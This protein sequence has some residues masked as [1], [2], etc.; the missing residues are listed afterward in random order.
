VRPFPAPATKSFRH[1]R[2][3]AADGGDLAPTSTRTS[4]CVR[5]C[6]HPIGAKFLHPLRLPPRGATHEKEHC[7]CCCASMQQCTIR[8]VHPVPAA[9]GT[10]LA[11]I[12]LS[13]A[14]AACLLRHP[15]TPLGTSTLKPKGWNYLRPRPRPESPA[16]SALAIAP[17]DEVNRNTPLRRF[18]SPPPVSDPSALK[19]G[20]RTNPLLCAPC[21]RVGSAVA[22]R[23]GGGC[24][25]SFLPVTLPV[26]THRD[27]C[28]GGTGR[29]RG[30]RRPACFRRPR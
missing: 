10:A 14:T 28:G 20:I 18:A 17:L 22:E 25:G 21:R 6:A 11:F 1:T 27:R 13:C 5:S 29:L 3:V 26:P 24:A 23:P 30:S 7:V 2:A 8:D 9:L 4:Q 12:R 16:L 15:G 19:P